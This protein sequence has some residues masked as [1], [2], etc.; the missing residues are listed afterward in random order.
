MDY[1]PRDDL[2]QIVK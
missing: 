2:L 1:Q